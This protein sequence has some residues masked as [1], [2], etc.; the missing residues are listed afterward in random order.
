MKRIFILLI[1]SL[2]II[3]SLASCDIID[4]G[5]GGT[6]AQWEQV[7]K[8]DDWTR[9]APDCVIHCTDGDVKLK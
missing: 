7:E 4:I 8:T 1:I 6:V 2:L 5:N 3:A 9:L